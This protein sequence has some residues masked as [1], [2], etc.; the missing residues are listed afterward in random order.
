MKN[1]QTRLRNMA[2][3]AEVVDYDMLLDV[4][5]LL[6]IYENALKLIS[7]SGKPDLDK[8]QYRLGG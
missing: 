6:D 3:G 8:G 2:D 4:A 1:L 7:E 5:A